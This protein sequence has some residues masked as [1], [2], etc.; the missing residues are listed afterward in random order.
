M[1]GV[2]VDDIHKARQWIRK[3]RICLTETLPPGGAVESLAAQ[4]LPAYSPTWRPNY[5]QPVL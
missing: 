5:V 3:K 4:E 1:K 2:T